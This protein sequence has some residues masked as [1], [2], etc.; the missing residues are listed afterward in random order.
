MARAP[1]RRL[2]RRHRF[3]T[4]R[5]PI[6]RWSPSDE[7]AATSA[8]LIR[9]RKSRRSVVTTMMAIVDMPT[10]MPIGPIVRLLRIFGVVALID[11]EHAFHAADD[12]AD[13]S[14]DDSADWASDAVAFIK[15]MSGASGNALSLYGYRHSKRCETRDAN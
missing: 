6:H 3:K 7:F 5:S 10:M 14:A 9:K 11:A 15:A 12:A 8:G 2:K 13:R 4:E 1:P